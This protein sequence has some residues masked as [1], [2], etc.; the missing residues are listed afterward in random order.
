MVA[1]V[2][3]VVVAVSPAHHPSRVTDAA[4]TVTPR[5]DGSVRVEVHWSE[6]PVPRTGQISIDLPRAH[7][8]IFV[9]AGVPPQCSAHVQRPLTGYSS[10]AVGY[11]L[12]DGADGFVVR[13]AYFPRDGTF[14]YAA[15]LAS[16]YDPHGSTFAPDRL[17]V[18]ATRSTMVVGRVP[19]CFPG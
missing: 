16:P 1:V 2:V 5:P 7:T 18:A 3:A 19:D 13:P 17:P 9:S 11:R 15:Q 10:K 14:L 4:Y 12:P 8:R 6:L